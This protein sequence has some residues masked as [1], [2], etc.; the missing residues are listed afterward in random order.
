MIFL[1]L[2][3]IP[4]DIYCNAHICNIIIKLQYNKHDIVRLQRITLMEK[5]EL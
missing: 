1:H 3:G 4:L 5:F 2:I